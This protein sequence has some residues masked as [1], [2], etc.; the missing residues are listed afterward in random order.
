MRNNFSEDSVGSIFG[1]ECFTCVLKMEAVGF[2]SIF[3]LTKL[4]GITSQK[5]GI[6][7]YEFHN[8]F[9]QK[10]KPS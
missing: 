2:A 10:R 4:H 5:S 3:V 7:I 8:I 1:A 9:S 6:Q